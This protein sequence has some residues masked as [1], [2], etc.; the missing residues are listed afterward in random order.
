MIRPELLAPAGSPEALDAAA[1]EGAD[2]VYL[3][4]KSFNARMR[5][6]NF[7]YAQFEGA[8]RSMHRMGRKVYVTVNTVFEERES[9]RMYQLLKYLAAVGPDGIILQDFGTLRMARDEFPSLKLHAS[10][11]MNIASSRAVNLLSKQGVCRVVLARE[12]SLE[13]IGHI[14]G[15][16]NMELE[17]FVHGALCVSASGLCLFSGFLG[18]KSANRGMCTQACRRLYR[19]EGGEGYYFSPAD[20]ELVRDIP[21]LADAGIN[22]FKIEGRMK[23]AEYVGVV[24]AAYRRIIDALDG[25][26]EAGIREGLAL[27][28]NDY[29]RKKTRFYFGRS[30]FPGTGEEALPAA[31]IDWLNPGQ[32]GGTGIALGAILRVRGGGEGRRAL[33]PGGTVRP[34]PGDSVRFH[35]SDD[36]GRLAHRLEAVERDDGGDAP[37]WWI[38]AP[39]GFETGDSVYL[40]QSR[41]M[42]KRYPQ[43]IPRN[44]EAY[45]RCPGRDR[46][47]VLTMPPAKRRDPRLFPEGLYVAVSRPGDLF[48][49]QSVRPVRV[50]LAWNH[51]TRTW[52]LGET[53]DRLPFRP[54][55]III[56]LDPY[57]PEAMDAPLEADIIRLRSLGYGQFVV[58]NPGQ[59]SCFRDSSGEFPPPALI[60]GPCLYTYNRRALAFVASL[61][62]DSVISPPENNRQNL[63]RTL[64]PGRR[65]FSFVTVFSYPVLFRIRGDLGELY[66]FREFQ[67]VRGEGFRLLCG[68]ADGSQV[69]PERPFSIVDKIPFLREAG[70]SRFIVDLSGPLL[71]KKDY[72]DIMASAMSG[73]PLPDVS[74][75]NWKD[76][77]FSE[78]KG[79][80]PVLSKKGKPEGA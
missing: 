77:F 75:F 62:T 52:L 47:P 57:F 80:S 12:L 36:S 4:L 13:E 32:D 29:A 78:E 5:S 46:A 25:D 17:V 63:E 22:S 6:V 54:A 20:L 18:G 26:R 24:V 68:G 38:S 3:G 39:E 43:V 70:F 73:S 31:D 2:G 50:M 48:T 16:T 56:V 67:D 76:G 27:L 49:V 74:R 9:D 53:G 30:F 44:L 59:F 79:K 7:S 58:N 1:G 72:K 41:G 66:D 65:P 23:S 51:L 10:T 45:K 19:R 37:G 40:I 34:E 11:Q 14:R 35:R 21:A 61:G 33:I 8:L 71:K 64:E 55:E 42:S 28:R 60:A 15:Q 69:I